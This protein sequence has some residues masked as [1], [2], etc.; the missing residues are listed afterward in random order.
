VFERFTI[1]TRL[2]VLSAQKEARRLRHRQIAT[3]HLLLALLQTGPGQTGDIL[4][5]HGVD[6]EAVER[7][8]RALLDHNPKADLDDA[9]VLAALGINVAHLRATIEAN[10]GQ[11]ALDRVLDDNGRHR[12]LTRLADLISGRLTHRRRGRTHHDEVA[13]LRIAGGRPVRNP[14][15]SSTAKKALELSL[16]EAIRLGD[17]SIDSDHLLLGLLRCGNGG[18]A[19]VLSALGTDTAALRAEIKSR[20]RRS[21]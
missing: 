9:Q 8:L 4:R 10:F 15:F 18:A 13:T 14:R 12:L 2:A 21:A 19:A 16:R 7:E 3:P 20:H 11:G 5:S 1:S 6:A 17:R